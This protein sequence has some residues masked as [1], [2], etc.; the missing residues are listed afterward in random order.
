[1]V[2]E[3]RPMTF[4]RGKFDSTN[5]IFSGRPTPQT[6]T[7]THTTAP[8]TDM[9]YFLSPIL[10]SFFSSLF[11]L[12]HSLSLLARRPVAHLYIIARTVTVWP[13][14]KVYCVLSYIRTNT[15]QC[16]C[17]YTRTMRRIIYSGEYPL[18]HYLHS[19]R[20]CTQRLRALCTCTVKFY[21]RYWRRARARAP[22][23]FDN[24]RENKPFRFGTV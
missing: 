21:T 6:H 2:L 4:P 13:V 15:P 14:V 3:R 9:C 19:P 23:D 7:H 16:S 1:M 10:F 22:V 20:M 8:P 24:F 17:T 11:S 18:V 12:S 5:A